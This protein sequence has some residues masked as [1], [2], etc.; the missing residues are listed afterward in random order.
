[1]NVAETALQR[2]V[3]EQRGATRCV[4]QQIDGLCRKLRGLRRGK[5][6]VCAFAQRHLSAGGSGV[7]SL[8][9]RIAEES[10][11]SPGKIRRS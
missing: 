10:D 11:R 3:G 2:V 9:D 8:V 6:H 7:P 5:S 1:M 4:E